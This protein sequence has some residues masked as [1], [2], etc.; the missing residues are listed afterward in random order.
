MTESRLGSADKYLI[1]SF[2]VGANY[3]VLGSLPSS[4]NFIVVGFSHSYTGKEDGVTQPSD[5]QSEHLQR[6]CNNY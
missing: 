3:I 5:T 2:T 1:N 6:Y 4:F